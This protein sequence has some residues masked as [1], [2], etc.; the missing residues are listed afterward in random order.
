MSGRRAAQ[1]A[2][3]DL[4]PQM[5][6]HVETFRMRERRGPEPARDTSPHTG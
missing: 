1:E 4:G 2:R 6:R 3:A 5:V